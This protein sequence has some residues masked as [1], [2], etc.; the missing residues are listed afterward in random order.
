M[1]GETKY[2]SLATTT[3]PDTGEVT[4]FVFGEKW[5]P[6][7]TGKNLYEAKMKMKEAFGL[8]MLFNSFWETFNDRVNKKAS[9]LAMMQKTASELEKLEKSLELL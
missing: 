6:V 5:G 4:M 9:E 1:K 2:V 7:V 8:A 3:N